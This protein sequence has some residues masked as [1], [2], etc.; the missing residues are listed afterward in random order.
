ML[1]KNSGY[2]STSIYNPSSDAGEGEFIPQENSENPKDAQHDIEIDKKLKV[3]Q[4]VIMDYTNKQE[5]NRSQ[6][7]REQRIQL[8]LARQKLRKEGVP[9]HDI[10]RLFPVPAVDPAYFDLFSVVPGESSQILSTDQS[11]LAESNT[12]NIRAESNIG[13]HVLEIRGKATE[14]QDPSRYLFQDDVAP[15]SAQDV[16]AD[17]GGNTGEKENSFSEWVQDPHMYD[18][19]DFDSPMVSQSEDQT[20]KLTADANENP[21]ADANDEGREGRS[22]R[23]GRRSTLDNIAANNSLP[24]RKR[25]KSTKSDKKP[26]KKERKKSL[27]DAE[28]LKKEYLKNQEI[29]EIFEGKKTLSWAPFVAALKNMVHC[30]FYQSPAL[31]EAFL[32]NRNNVYIDSVYE[33]LDNNSFQE[34]LAPFVPDIGDAEIIHKELLSRSPDANLEQPLQECVEEGY[35]DLAEAIIRCEIPTTETLQLNALLYQFAR[36]DETNLLKKMLKAGA[37]PNTFVGSGGST[38]LHWAASRGNVAACRLLLEHGAE[39]DALKDDGYTPLNVAC[40]KEHAEVAELL[41]DHQADV[42]IEA[43]NQWTPL[44]NAVHYGLYELVEMLIHKGADVNTRLPKGYTPLTVAA[45][46]GEYRAFQLLLENGAS[47]SVTTMDGKTLMDLA[48]KHEHFNI[49]HLLSQLEG[50]E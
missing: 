42:H 1:T 33:A 45:V 34:F 46:Q 7:I 37:D 12:A 40:S 22:L 14:K 9:E 27:G 11:I 50:K 20:E 43:K 28:T 19:N 24:T 38:C 10:E 35:E 30:L 39:V 13:D 6:I 48:I 29:E 44:A 21:A 8:G 32:K 25:R 15:A 31:K 49:V 41:L 3:R 26:L 16:D 17:H 5:S 2:D 23:S 18:F 47:P 36:N 4:K